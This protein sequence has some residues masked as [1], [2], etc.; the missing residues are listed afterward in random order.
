MYLPPQPRERLIDDWIERHRHPISFALHMVGIP[1][2]ILGVLM[3][4][5]YLTEWSS[6]LFLFAMALFGGGYLIQFLGHLLDGSEPGEVT[7]LRSWFDQWRRG[8][9]TQAVGV[10]AAA[11][12]IDKPR[13]G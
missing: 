13:H 11:S 7:G 6:T 2:T 1:A 10:G 3:I 8:S 9:Q 4:P 5:I 12:A